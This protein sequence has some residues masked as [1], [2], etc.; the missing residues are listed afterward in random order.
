MSRKNENVFFEHLPNLFF[1]GIFQFFLHIECTQSHLASAYSQLQ[2]FQISIRS[3]YG[4]SWFCNLC[5]Y[6][7]I[8]HRRNILLRKKK[9][10]Q[11]NHWSITSMKFSCKVI[12]CTACLFFVW[13]CGGAFGCGRMGEFMIRHWYD[14]L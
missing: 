9:E 3:R 11:T 12:H 10:S 13:L 14:S 2:N 1:W 6:K 8:I 4:S 7:L 5:T